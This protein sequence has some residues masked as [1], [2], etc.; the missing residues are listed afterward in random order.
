MK[1]KEILT[2]ALLVIVS[3]LLSNELLKAQEFNKKLQKY[4]GTLATEI[5]EVEKSRIPVLDSIAESIIRAKKK[6]GKSK[7]LLVCTHNSRRS[8]IAQMWLETAA[9]YYKV[10]EIYT[11][12]GGIEVTAA[13]KRAIDA[14]GRAGFNTSVSNKNSENPI[15]M[16]TQ[17]GGH[18]TSILYSKKYDD[19]QNPH[20]NFIACN[21]LL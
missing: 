4:A 8:H 16:I 17:G 9:L 14:L 7:I 15:Y 21:G 10:K 18:S 12:S 20:E 19:S 5:G 13:N 1:T 3:L 2:T 6:Y 11:F